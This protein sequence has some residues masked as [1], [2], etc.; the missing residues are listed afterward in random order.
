VIILDFFLHIVIHQSH[1][2]GDNERWLVGIDHLIGEFTMSENSNEYLSEVHPIAKDKKTLEL[3]EQSIDR[4]AFGF[5][6]TGEE[7]A[8]FF[9]QTYTWGAHKVENL[10][11]MGKLYPKNQ[12]ILL[13][14][15]DYD[16]EGKWYLD[17]NLYGYDVVATGLS[18]TDEIKMTYSSDFMGYEEDLLHFFGL[19]LHDEIQKC[20]PFVVDS[21]NSAGKV[22]N[23]VDESENSKIIHAEVIVSE[24][25]D[26]GKRV[27]EAAKRQSDCLNLWLTPKNG[28]MTADIWEDSDDYSD[29]LLVV[30]IVS[31]LSWRERNLQYGMEGLE[32]PNISHMGKYGFPIP[33]EEYLNTMEN[34]YDDP[35][36]LCQDRK[37]YIHRES[38]EAYLEGKLTGAE[39]INQFGE[40]VQRFC[41]EYQFELA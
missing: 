9:S 38:A 10:Q 39:V 13:A 17:G 28:K 1:R 35:R 32:K 8:Q 36:T 41:E 6:A 21:F 16:S 30:N 12:I 23:E 40:E 3:M 7:I 5:E 14:E 24:L 33:T 2:V 26:A 20:H 4:V 11:K 27:I 18:D 15:P 22:V 19:E 31:K 29:D 34:M 37:L 25:S